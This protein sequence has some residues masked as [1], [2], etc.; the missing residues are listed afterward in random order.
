[1]SKEKKGLEYGWVVLSVTTI[2]ILMASIQSSALLISLPD[3][4]K[5]LHMDFLTVMWVILAYMLVTTVAVPVFGRLADMFG[6]KRLYV[7]GFAVFS[8]GSLL[9]ALAD[10]RF[11]GY[12][13][14]GYR[15]IQ[16]VGGALMM[17]NGAAMVVDAFDARKL[18]FGLGVNM[19]AGGAGIVL[20]PLVG[21]ALSPLGWQWI[22]LINVPIGV[23]GTI[24]ALVRLREPIKMPKGQSF[25]WVG[26][27]LFTVGLTAF[28]LGLTFIAF[29]GMLGMEMVYVLF[30]VGGLGIV[31]FLYVQTKVRH[32]MM[33]LTLFHNQVFALGNTTF[34]L[35]SLCRGAVLFLLV[36]FLQGPYGQD[37]LT[38][39]IS[40]IP[41]GIT[42]IIVG[43]LSGKGSDRYGPRLFTIGGLVLS[44]VSLLG[45]AFVDHTTPFWFL[46]VLMVLMGIGGGLFSSPNSSTVMN[47]VRPEKRGIASGTRTMLGNVGSMF[48]LALAFP[49][50]LANIS[51]AEMAKLFIV[52]GG[53]GSEALHTFEGGLHLAFLLFFCTSVAAVIISMY[54][55]KPQVAKCDATVPAATVE[56]CDKKTV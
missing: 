11:N 12:D 37:P 5:S 4:M 26:S 50:V 16:G 33:D 10:A 48:S 8:L 39:G 45:F 6:R 51:S 36:F 38:A 19:V 56:E 25:D 14:I 20:G 2:G 23:I 27:T 3:M 46:V 17:A 22:F 52:G 7:L 13:L 42:F 18:G 9:C 40:L 31:A 53:L 29:P 49:L 1:M 34:F 24:W 30:I 15:I 41:F 32:P 44:S 47:T 35:N 55:P 28:L 43:P 54:Q 21:G